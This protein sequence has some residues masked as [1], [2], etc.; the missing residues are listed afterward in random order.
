MFFFNRKSTASVD[1]LA[2]SMAHA[3][4]EYTMA[5]FDAE[6]TSWLHEHSGLQGK[7]ELLQEWILYR[8]FCDISGYRTSMNNPETNIRFSKTFLKTCGDIYI[9]KGVFPS[10]AEYEQLGKDRFNDYADAL[11]ELDATEAIKNVGQQFL[12]FVKC[13]QYDPALL[14]RASSIYTF[15]TIAAKETLNEMQQKFRLVE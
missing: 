11:D 6:R 12:I 4:T 5:N 1:K 3:A 8:L 13:S 7:P 9:A 14:L 10:M 2:E 15:Y